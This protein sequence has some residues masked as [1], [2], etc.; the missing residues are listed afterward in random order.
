M[1]FA[2]LVF[3]GFL[4]FTSSVTNG[5]GALQVTSVGPSNV[6]LNGRLLGVTPLCKC[7]AQSM[8]PTGEY[9]IRLVPTDSNL[10]N[11]TFEEKITINKGVLTVV[12]RTFGLGA[13]S[14]GSVISLIPQDNK[15]SAGLFV[16]SFPDNADISIDD[17]PN[18]QTPF[19]QANITES[20]HD[21]A[22]TKNGYKAKQIR[23][24][25][26]KGYT[27]S[28]IAFLGV[29]PSV[30]ASSTGELVAS[31][32]AEPAHQKIIILDTPTGFLRVRKDANI[33]SLE[34]GQVKPTEEYPLVAEQTDW[35]QIKLSN[36][37]LGWVSSTYAKKE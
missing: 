10:T 28:V 6:Y 27:L 18:G 14:Q 29:D 34:I 25:A 13:L 3:F 21:I 4:F 15:N 5:K 33:S 8:F 11:E 12:D 37:V 20:D 17:N 19:R 31:V 24:H 16:A 32:S 26:V 30:V 36:G 22:I 7:D 1:V 9:T 35:Y 23:I 2:L